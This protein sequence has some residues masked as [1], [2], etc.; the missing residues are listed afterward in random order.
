MDQQPPQAQPT[1]MLQLL[2][3]TIPTR[4]FWK[5]RESFYL[6]CNSLFASDAGLSS[7][8]DI[9]GKSDYDMPWKEQA[10]IYRADDSTVMNTG[11]PKLGYEEPQTTA[12]GRTVH[13][14][15]NKVPLKD[16]DGQIIG[17]MG[18]YEDITDR[19]DAEEQLR[20]RESLYRTMFE[21][22][23][24]SVALTNLSGEFV[25]VN[26]R[27]VEIVGVPREEALGRTPVAL[28]IMDLA[29]Q[30]TVLEEI[31]RTGGRL[32]GYEIIVQTRS[33]ETKWALVSTALVSLK[34]EPLILSIVNDITERRQ[35][36][37]ALRRSEEKYRE[38]VQN[39]NSIILRWGRDGTVHF[40]NEFAQTFFGYTEEEILGRNVMGTI[41]AETETSGRDLQA[42]IAEITAHPEYHGTNVNENMR[43]N[44][45]RMWVAWTNKPVFDENG[46][47]AEI[48]SVGLDISTRI[49][50]QLALQES[51]TRYRSIFNS[52]VDAFVLLDINGCVVDANA[53]A[54]ELYGYSREELMGLCAKDVVDPAYSHLFDS[55]AA[56][57][58][59]EWLYRESSHIRR[60]GT[61]FDVELHGTKLRYSGVE[62]LL[63]IVFDVTERK[64]AE[65]ALQQSEARFRAIYERAPLGIALIDSFTGRFLQINP[66]YC[67]IVGRDQEGMLKLNF[68]TITH[69][70][71]LQADLDNMRSLVEGRSRFFSMEKRYIH[72][73][74]SVVWVDMTIVPM[75]DE[76][77]PP[78][79]HIAMVEDITERKRAEEDKR[80]FYRRTIEAATEGKL[81][82][83][84]RAEIEQTAGPPIAAY[85]VTSGQDLSV[86]R[87]ATSEVAESNGM[88]DSKLFDL[89]VCLGEAAT[90]AIKHAGGGEVSVHQRD[91]ALLALVIDNGPGVQAINRPDV[92]LRRGYSTAI[93]LGMGYKLMISL[94]DQVYLTTGP[95]GTAVAI[96][97]SLHS[98]GKPPVGTPLPDSW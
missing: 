33:G 38:L 29:T 27:F 49:H 5:D 24:F 46:D 97:V 67:E 78:T 71:D 61:R 94:A 98:T 23:P 47:I 41:V 74:G 82:I 55:F 81:I 40:F 34:D 59:G 43:K 17:M 1:W 84:D 72:T 54:G 75:W 7:P 51:E 3:D 21:H 68:Q 20:D 60:D 11:E 6:G 92:A 2:L 95:S 22:S 32:D 39:A 56:I 14:R 62:R 90:N 48:L 85:Q 57:S 44:G 93:S 89:L 80:R 42:M 10:D 76:G 19:L 77:E 65:K 63:A 36:E 96:E 26:E 52:N 16:E 88:D 28:G 83:C 87:R 15:K 69:P 18:I 8:D 50:D 35:A 58:A 91:G 45:E 86:V 53:R 37:E 64:R 12:D 30:A 70:D 25:D 79:C 73:D 9:V 13:L 31:G 4:V 66:R